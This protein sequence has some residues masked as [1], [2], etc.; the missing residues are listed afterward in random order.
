MLN[1]EF[2]MF[3]AL[4]LNLWAIVKDSPKVTE[5]PHWFAEEFNTVIQKNQPGFSDLYQLIYMVVNESQAQLWIKTANW[6]DS[7]KSSE[8]QL[9]G[10]ESPAVLIYNQAWGIAK[11]PHLAILRPFPKLV[12]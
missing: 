11:Q 1:P 7:K 8:W 9:G 3:P 10:K 2:L 5:D 6:N 12:D 4:K